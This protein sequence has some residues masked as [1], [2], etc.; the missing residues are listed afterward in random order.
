MKTISNE[1]TEQYEIR[2]NLLLL[3]LRTMNTC[4]KRKAN[5]SLGTH[6]IGVVPSST[7]S[8]VQMN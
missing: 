4:T 6:R 3:S 2:L 1:P 7:S 5:V 8:R